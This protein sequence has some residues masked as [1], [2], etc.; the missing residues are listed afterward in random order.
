VAIGI[1]A[2]VTVGSQIKKKLSKKG[3]KHEKIAVLAEDKLSAVSG[4]ISKALYDGEISE[5]EYLL[6]VS[7]FDKFREM[8]EKIRAKT[9][10]TTTYSTT[11]SDKETIG[12]RLSRVMTTN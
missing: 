11:Y 4:Y 6:I 10:D 9:K 2:L 3:G 7:E 8:K 1:G 5:E 12:Q